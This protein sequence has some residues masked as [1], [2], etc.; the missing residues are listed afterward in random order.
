M[1]E[2]VHP[3]LF[4]AVRD[5]GPDLIVIANGQDGNQFDPN[6]RNL[7]SM[8]GFRDLGRVANELSE[9][10]CNG[11]LLLCQEGGYAVTYTGF[12]MYA[13]AEGI[14][15][16]DEP[17]E[18]PLA[19]DATIEQPDVPMAQIEQINDRWRRLCASQT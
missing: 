19:Y 3:P 11:R 1:N 16:V 7:L 8:T 6:G 10:L 15:G 14:L 13:V 18:D 9:E 17:M 4:P 12:C 2:P 5:F